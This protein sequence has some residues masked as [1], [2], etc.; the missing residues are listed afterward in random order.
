MTAAGIPARTRWAAVVLTAVAALI[1]L[2]AYLGPLGFGP[3]LAV[4]GLCLFPLWA[5]RPLGRREMLTFGAL[6]L[7]GLGTYAWSPVAPSSR[8][9]LDYGAIED[10][11]GLKLVFQLPLYAA[12]VFAAS[13]LS[14]SAA[15]RFVTVLATWLGVIAAVLT[16]DAAVG[17]PL[18]QWLT[19]TFDEPLR[20]DIAARE[21]GQ[22]T[23]VA[24]VLLWPCALVL[25]RTRLR[26]LTIALFACAVLGGIVLQQQ[27]AV[28][29]VALGGLGYWLVLR[30]GAAAVRGLGALSAVVL[31]AA[32]WLVQAAAGAG[33]FAAIA[34]VLPASWEA[35]VSI[36]TFAAAR[37]AERP[38]FGWGLDASRSFS[39]EIPLHP[40][41]M[42]IQLWLELGAIGAG[43]GALV[44]WVTLAGVAR[45]AKHDRPAAGA[46]V[47]AAAAYFVIGN[48]SF[49]VWQEWWLALGAVA[50]ALCASLAV[51]RAHARMAEAPAPLHPNQLQPL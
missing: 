17:V 45:L 8:T 1:P 25:N 40:H 23:V 47:G 44:W 4:A 21:V 18:Y 27:S 51:A 35:R 34:R 30:F 49:G 22:G 42:S 41:A 31:L 37:I 11:V 26:V 28:I 14:G 2:M 48:L 20:P 33:L 5:K 3:L 15:E 24:A 29:A 7:W 10:L 16:I 43:L 6:V 50:A 13:S 38:I 32:P 9:G 12:V 19:A 46:A 36:W 39:P